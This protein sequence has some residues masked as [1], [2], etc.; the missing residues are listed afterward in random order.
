[1]MNMSASEVEP[2]WEIANS[3]LNEAIKVCLEELDRTFTDAFVDLFE[4]FGIVGKREEDD[5]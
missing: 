3:K 4:E 1:M 2:A 5:R